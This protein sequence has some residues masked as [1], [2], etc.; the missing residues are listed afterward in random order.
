MSEALSIQIKR[1]RKERGWSQEDLAKRCKVKR[2]TITN[3]ESETAE[4]SVIL[5]QLIALAFDCTLGFIPI[6]PLQRYF[7]IL[8]RYDGQP[9]GQC[10]LEAISDV[11]A[12]EPGVTFKEITAEE[13]HNYSLKEEL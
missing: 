7:R 11:L 3:I 4:P 9:I 5:L 13:W 1:M 12:D 10:M 2:T 8:S 6:T